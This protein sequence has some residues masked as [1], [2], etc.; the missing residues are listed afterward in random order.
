MEE[1]F[2][3]QRLLALRKLT[4]AI[5]D[6]LREQMKEYLSTLAPLLR[7]RVVLGDYI[8]G[9]AK[10]MIKGADKAFKDLQSIYETVAG[11]KPFNLIKELSSPIEIVSSGLEMFP[12]EYKHLAKMGGESKTITITSPLRWVLTYSGFPLGRLKELISDRGR[13]GNELQQFVLHYLVMHLVITKQQG[14]TTI[15]DALHFP[16]TSYHSPE[17]S[18]LPITCISS[19][20]STIRPPDEVIIESTEIS[21][22][23]VFEEIVNLDDIMKIRDPLKERLIELARNYGEQ[24]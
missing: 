16:I 1:G 24:L 21:G 7:P 3:F 6:L 15:L 18:D 2:N 13:V 5:T 20:I 17:L 10:E 8:Q 22:M 12:L 4:R 11:A 14:V 9:G 23:N 19:S